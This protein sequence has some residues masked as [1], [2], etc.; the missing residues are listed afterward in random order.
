[1]SVIKRKF[2]MMMMMM[3]VVCRDPLPPEREFFID[4]LLVRIHFTIVMVRWTGLAP[5]EFE[6]PFLG[7]LTSTFPGDPLPP[8][9]A[10][11]FTV[12]NRYFR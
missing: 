1:V 12:G 9:T 8:D 3:C 7:S 10:Q 6:Y 4:N 5:G 11:I 2:M